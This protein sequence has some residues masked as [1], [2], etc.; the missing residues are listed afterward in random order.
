MSLLDRRGFH[1][2]GRVLDGLRFG[3][4]DQFIRFADALDD[5]QSR[6]GSDDDRANGE[7]VLMIDHELLGLLEL[8]PRL[9]QQPPRLAHLAQSL[10]LA[11]HDRH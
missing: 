10:H 11:R 1:I 2:V 9:P 5:R 6:N 3:D 8:L 7:L 4:I